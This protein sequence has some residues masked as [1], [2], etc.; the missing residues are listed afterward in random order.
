MPVHSERVEWSDNKLK[1]LLMEAQDRQI[2]D[3]EIVGI[4]KGWLEAYQEAYEDSA[5]EVLKVL[6]EKPEEEDTRGLDYFG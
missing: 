4:L 3:A 2:L 1:K 5:Q 6:H